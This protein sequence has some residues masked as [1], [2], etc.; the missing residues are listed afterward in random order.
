MFSS[1][2][3]LSLSFDMAAS[4]TSMDVPEGRWAPEAMD[5][6][7]G[8]PADAGS[9]TGG[10]ADGGQPEN[11]EFSRGASAERIREKQVKVLRSFLVYCI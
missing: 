7:G 3:V 8:P 9:V 2:R 6:I 1:T 10:T 5:S 11:P 4:P